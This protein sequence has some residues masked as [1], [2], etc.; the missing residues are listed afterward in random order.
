M[1]GNVQ[2]R[3]QR[4]RGTRDQ[5]ANICWIMEKPRELQ[6]NSASLTKLKPLTVWITAN[7]GKFLDSGISDHLTCLLGNLYTA[8]ESTVEPD[9][10]QLTGS[11]LG[12][13]YD[14]A[15]YCHLVYLTYM[16]STPHEM[17][18]ES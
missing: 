3:F 17:L 10:E 9:M 1:K 8:Q 13:E 6:K 15:V 14:N 16:Q 18:E 7:Y 5:I 11:K 12:K 2:T 4:G